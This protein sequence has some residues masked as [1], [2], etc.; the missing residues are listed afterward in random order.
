MEQFIC[1]LF[2]Y[3]VDSFILFFPIRCYTH[4]RGVCYKDPIPNEPPAPSVFEQGTEYLLQVCCSLRL[5]HSV[6]C[7]GN[8]VNSQ[9][10]PTA[11]IIARSQILVTGKKGAASQENNISCLRRRRKYRGAVIEPKSQQREE[12]E[13]GPHHCSHLLPVTL[14]SSFLLNLMKLF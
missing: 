4:K 10:E 2:V 1:E 11:Q 6:D 8:C 14:F 3:S 13:D 5:L 12:V 7:R 9:I